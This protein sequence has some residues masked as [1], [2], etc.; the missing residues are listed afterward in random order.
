[1]AHVSGVLP[2]RPGTTRPISVTLTVIAYLAPMKPPGA[3]GRWGALAPALA[4]LGVGVAFYATGLASLALTRGLQSIAAIWPCNAVLLAAFLLAPRRARWRYFAAGGLASLLMNL[5]A[6]RSVRLTLAFTA[7]NLAGPALATWL[8]RRGRDTPSFVNPRDVGRFGVAAV[9]AA[10]LGVTLSATLSGLGTP[11]FA[12]S[13]LATDLLSLL[14][15][16]PIILVW[17]DLVRT[18]GE[19]GAARPAPLTTALVLAAVSAVAAVTFAQSAFPLLFLPLA[20]LVAATFAL[21]PLGATTS[22]LLIALIGAALT[23][24]G[25]GPVTLAH[26]GTDAALFFFQFYLLVLLASALPLAALLAARDRLH[27]A[28]AEANRLLGQAEQAAGVGHWRLDVRRQ[29][30]FWSP[31]VFRIHGRTGAQPP[32]FEDAIAD[33]HP[34]DRAAVMAA[35]GPALA[36][37]TPIEVEARLL[38]PDGSLRHVAVQGWAELGPAGD[39]RAL[40]GAVQDV[41]ARVEAQRAAERDAALATQLADTDPLTGLPNRRKTLRLLD[42]A[43]AAAR[44]AG[45]PFAVALLDV[46]HFKSV[47]DRFGH[48]VGDEVLRRIARAAQG[49]LRRGD[50][51]GRLGGEEFVLL[52]FG[53]EAEEAMVGA[54]RVRAAVAAGGDA[55][56]AA[57]GSGAPVDPKVTVSLG[58]AVSA[59]EPAAELLG[60]ADQAL[61]QAKH[62]GRNALSLAA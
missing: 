51:V 12:A 21:G 41:T 25:R 32:S 58:V 44:V 37:G 40:C 47:N 2:A 13:W 10:L 35:V 49:A 56:G 52:F 14:I 17:A 45:Q 54:E 16:T 55:G 50:V 5:Q 27:R 31:E 29:E 30:L 39:V 62:A 11:G 20:A 4:P 23:G 19:D 24:Q 46:D 1:M 8:L 33:Y 48:A 22:V 34:D 38:R 26:G 3:T 43:V 9:A 42:D 6:G 18:R 57:D 28:L 59:G 60:R 53:S 7:A 61:Y 36:T 15:V